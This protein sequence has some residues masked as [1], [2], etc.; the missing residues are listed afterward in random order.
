[1]I[2][3]AS[4]G[5]GLAS[6]IVLAYGLNA[7]TMGVSFERAATEEKTA[8]PGWYNN[9]AFSEFAKRDGL[10]EKLLWEMLFRIFKESIISKLKNSLTEN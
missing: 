7:N 8:T 3:G 1:M 10:K 9:Q 2:L 4:G 6:R 5:Y